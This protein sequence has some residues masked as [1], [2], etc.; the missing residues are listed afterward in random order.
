MSYDI[1][2]RDIEIEDH[3]YERHTM[4]PF[5]ATLLSRRHAAVIAADA[6]HD[7]SRITATHVIHTLLPP[8]RHASYFFA[9]RRRAVAFDVDTITAHVFFF[10]R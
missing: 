6:A 3:H 4:L 10:T 5:A 1:D 8:C 9:I 2:T 7:I